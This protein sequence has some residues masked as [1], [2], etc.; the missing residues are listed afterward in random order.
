MDGY[1]FFS[2]SALDLQ[3]LKQSWTLELA[4][5]QLLPRVL[6]QPPEQQVLQQGLLV[7]RGL[8]ALGPVLELQQELLAL[9][10]E[11]ELQQELLVL[12]LGPRQGLL[13]PVLELLLV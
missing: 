6:A 4:L 8:L 3:Q 7:L 10:P 11:L 2:F 1:L 13:V 9:E 12:E 5:A